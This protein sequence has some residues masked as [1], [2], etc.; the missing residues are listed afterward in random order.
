MKSKFTY[1]IL[2]VMVAVF[3]SGTLNAQSSRCNTTGYDNVLTPSTSFETYKYGE[4]R[5][6]GNINVELFM[7]VFEP[8]GDTATQRPLVIIAFGGSFIG[9]QKEDLHQVCQ[10]YASY[11]YVAATIDYR[12][13]NL[14]WGLDL[15]NYYRAILGAMSDMKAS[16]RYFKNDAATENNFRIDTNAIF[17]GGYSA[18]A[19][20]ALNTGYLDDSDVDE[21]TDPNVLQALQVFGDLEGDTGDPALFKHST[22]VLGVLNMSGGMFDAA[23][24]DAG[25]PMLISMHGTNDDTVPYG[26]GLALGFLPVSGSEV[27]HNRALAQNIDSY[28]HTI[29][30]GGHSNIYLDPLYAEDFLNFFEISLRIMNDAICNTTVSTHE[31]LLVNTLNAKLFP[32]PAQDHI[33]IEAEEDILSFEIFNMNGQS[34]YRSSS[35]TGSQIRLDINMLP[36]AGS[37]VYY[38]HLIGK[39]GATSILKIMT[40]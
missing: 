35:Y 36:L 8:L 38:F 34:I 7:D 27:L 28:L 32:I 12:L 25:E 29:L 14:I 3:L 24:I 13:Y 40:Q 22:D 33:T 10:I 6:L 17:V 23:M 2:I 4:N 11:G 31:K 5:N 20:T 26:Q 19:F 15:V 37:G 18:G 21:L 30:G 39:S 1:S 9:G 16:I